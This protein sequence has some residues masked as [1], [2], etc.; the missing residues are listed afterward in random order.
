VKDHRLLEPAKM[1]VLMQ[2]WTL[3]TAKVGTGNGTGG[4]QLLLSVQSV[5]F[6][7]LLHL[8][9]GSRH[10]AAKQQ[11]QSRRRRQ[12]GVMVALLLALQLQEK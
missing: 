7:W 4:A 8:F 10:F 6:C 9:S 1:L 12:L 3:Q 11:R 5:G 2:H